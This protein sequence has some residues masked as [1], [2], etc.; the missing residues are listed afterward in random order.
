MSSEN[1]LVDA[2]ARELF[3]QLRAMLGP[4]EV[5]LIEE[6]SG[7]ITVTTDEWSLQFERAPVN[8]V[9]LAI[10]AEPDDPAEYDAARREV[11]S[12][13]VEALMAQID[14]SF[15]GALGTL[16]RASGDPFT[17]SLATAIER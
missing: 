10:D 4:E 1:N 8:R 7:S 13:G 12:E 5:D 14:R 17:G 15:D 6:T 2:L 16:L 11:V 9:W 3:E